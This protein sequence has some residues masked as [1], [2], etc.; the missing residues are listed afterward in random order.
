VLAAAESIS[1]TL[2]RSSS[3]DLRFCN[4]NPSAT[5]SA[6]AAH[7]TAEASGQ[8]A[9]GADAP[10]ELLVQT[11]PRRTYTSELSAN[12]KVGC[13]AWRPPARRQEATPDLVV[14]RR[15]V[16]DDSLV[17]EPIDSCGAPGEWIWIT[18]LLA[19]NTS[20]GRSDGS[21]SSSGGR[22]ARISGTKR[23]PEKRRRAP[24]RVISTRGLVQPSSSSGNH[25]DSPA[26]GIC[27]KI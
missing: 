11:L 26:N 13:V 7:R 21:W 5:R 2:L 3:L 23:A 4:R 24:S 9:S 14:F 6:P 22:R 20:V 1:Q 10:R 19:P 15:A 25:N 16:F 8:T 12:A 27:R 17:H 18:V